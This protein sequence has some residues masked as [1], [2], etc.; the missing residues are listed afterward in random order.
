MRTVVVGLGNAGHTLHLPALS[1]IQSAP[2][3]GT[4]DLD[5]ERRA[6]AESTWKVP[7]FDNYERMLEEASPSLW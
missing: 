1:K 6:R 7:V 2:V 4:C 3:V 5:P